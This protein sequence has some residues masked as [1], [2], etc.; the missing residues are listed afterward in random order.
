MGHPGEVGTPGLASDLTA[1]RQ[2]ARRKI[3]GVGGIA[4]L[5]IHDAQ[6]IP[7][8]GQAEHGAHKIG[9]ERR[10]NPGR[11]QDHLTRIGRRHR[12]LALQLGASV[13]ALG[14]RRVGLQIG[15]LLGPIE[16]IVGGELYDRGPRGGGGGGHGG[17][18]IP[19]DGEGDVRLAFSLVDIGIGGRIDHHVRPK[20]VD[21]RGHGFGAHQIQFGTRGVADDQIGV[22]DGDFAQS[23]SHLAL[24]ADDEQAKAHVEIMPRRSP[25]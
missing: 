3:H 7:I 13:D 9:P 24:R 2:Y 14:R 10:I 6:T 22:A 4:D 21:D 18:S 25:P 19:V 5:I 11:P 17:G 16:H 1:D 23:L 8:L 12:R 15:S 20:R